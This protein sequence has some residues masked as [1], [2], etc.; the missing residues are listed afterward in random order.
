MSKSINPTPDKGD[1]LGSVS[2]DNFTI[3]PHAVIRDLRLNANDVRLYGAIDAR[4]GQNTS[5][6]VYRQLLAADIGV[7]KSTISRSIRKLQDYGYLDVQLRGWASRYYLKNTSRVRGSSHQRQGVMSPMTPPQINN[8]SIN[9]Q[10]TERENSALEPVGVV[11]D[12]LTKDNYEKTA[13]KVI[14]AETGVFLQSN[15]TTRKHLDKAQRL[16]DSP[17]DYGKK[18]AQHFLGEKTRKKILSES[19]FIVAVSMPAILEGDNP[20]E[21]LNLTP[22][23]IP[24]KYE[25]NT[26]QACEHGSEVRKLSNGLPA[27]P[28]CRAATPIPTPSNALKESPLYEEK[29]LFE[30]VE[31]V[32]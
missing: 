32:S 1:T 8:F 17:H 4:Q 16:G 23:P 9:N 29:P 28:Q 11:V 18:V 22:T 14:T 19:G 3:I 25:P 30:Q 20:K 5:Q 2:R 31:R 15:A 6:A 7:S 21:P 10:N 27:C 24:P 13:L 12:E 26:F